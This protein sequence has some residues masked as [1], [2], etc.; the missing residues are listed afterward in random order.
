MS[1]SISN[2]NSLPLRALM[3]LAGPIGAHRHLQGGGASLL[4]QHVF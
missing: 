2:L 4:I 3:G 1:D